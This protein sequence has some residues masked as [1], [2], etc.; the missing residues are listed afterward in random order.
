M[1]NKPNKLEQW[2]NK[3]EREKH[4]LAVM[5]AVIFTSLVVLIWGYNFLGGLGDEKEIT[6]NEEYN[7]QFSPL[8]PL[9]NLF[10]DSLQKIKAGGEV[11]KQ[12]ASTVF[13][14][15]TIPTVK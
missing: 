4:T 14:G 10:S 2:R 8:A 13:G 9:K 3:T 1:E 7:K 12:S 6:K 15:V 11:V 5:G